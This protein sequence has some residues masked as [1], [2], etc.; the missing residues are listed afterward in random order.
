MIYNKIIYLSFKLTLIQ[1]NTRLFDFFN[2][3]T[4]LL[5]GLT[6]HNLTSAIQKILTN[7]MPV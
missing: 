5:I 1:N 7:K 4:T 3:F 2:F 6:Y